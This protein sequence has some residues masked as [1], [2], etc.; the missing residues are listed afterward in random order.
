MSIKRN[1]SI[2]A[3]ILVAGALLLLLFLTQGRVNFY[4]I[5]LA[6]LSVVT[7]ALYGYD[8]AQAKSGGMRVPEIVLHA[9]ALAGGFPGGWAGRSFFHHKTQKPVFT[10]VLS[11][12]TLIHLGIILYGTIS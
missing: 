4:W 2:L 10:L 12:S 9:L 8:K 1:F 3:V 6:A 7:F 5:W 11:I